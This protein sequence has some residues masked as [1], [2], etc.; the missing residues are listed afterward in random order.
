MM[1]QYLKTGVIF[2]IAISLFGCQKE[3][4]FPADEKVFA[5]PS[6]ELDGKYDVIGLKSE[7]P[8]DL[9]GDSIFSSDILKEA[10]L[11]SDSAKYFMELI[12]GKVGGEENLYYQ[13]VYLWI[14][15]T[16]IFVDDAGNYLST[17]YAVSRIFGYVR[18]YNATK[19]LKIVEKTVNRAGTVLDAKLV[20]EQIVVTFQQFYYTSIGWE[21]LTI[22]GTYKRRL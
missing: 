11:Q 2:L 3:I 18:Y 9:D 10:N 19:I 20:D 16:G 17:G 8:V 12:T 5:N 7:K 6:R 15:Q 13:Q 22:L 4:V 14:P 21:E 1:Q